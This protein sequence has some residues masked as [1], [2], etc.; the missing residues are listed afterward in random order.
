VDIAASSSSARALFMA[1]EAAINKMMSATGMS[2]APSL[3]GPALTM[4]EFGDPLP[5]RARAHIRM[6]SPSVLEKRV[7]Q[8]RNFT[9]A[10]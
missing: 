5:P 1:S 3:R 4:T 8:I 10:E 6:Y 9:E 7:N 2:P